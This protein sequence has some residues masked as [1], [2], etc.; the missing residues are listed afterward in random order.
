MEH[1]NLHNGFSFDCEEIFEMAV[2]HFPTNSHFVEIGLGQ[3]KSSGYM[4]VEIINSGKNIKLDC[5]DCWDMP[6]DETQDYTMGFLNN[7]EPIWDMLDISVIQNYST[8]ASKLYENNSLDFVFIDGDHSYG[9]VT[10]DIKH[11]LPKLKQNGLIAGHDYTQEYIN[12]VIPAV[13]TFFGKEKV[14][15]SKS[16]WYVWISDL[17]R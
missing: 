4:A 14:N 1:L 11:W 7:L 17:A 9:A 6:T 3:G 10:D 2:K 13:D 12:S 5:V 8:E 15:V 16:S